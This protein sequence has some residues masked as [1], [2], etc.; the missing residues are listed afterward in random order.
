M[1]IALL[2]KHSSAAEKQPRIHFSWKVNIFCPSII[3]AQV[4]CCFRLTSQY[5]HRTTQSDLSYLCTQG[6]KKTSFFFSL[7]SAVI[8][9]F[10]HFMSMP[11]CHC[12]AVTVSLVFQLPGRFK[13]TMLRPQICI[14][15]KLQHYTIPFSP[16]N[17]RLALGIGGCRLQVFMHVTGHATGLSCSLVNLEGL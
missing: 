4:S 7:G 16:C 15:F 8:L 14:T 12:I 1:Y 5:A 9:D 13:H 17:S 11:N 6:M 2:W 3:I 10:S